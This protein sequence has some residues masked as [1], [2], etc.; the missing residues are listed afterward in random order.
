[1]CIENHR[2]I[3]GT[4]IGNIWSFLGH[5]YGKYVQLTDLKVPRNYSSSIW[6]HRIS[7]RLWERP[8]TP[9]VH[10]FGIF[11]PVTKPQNQL[12]LFLETT[13]KKKQENPW[14]ILKHIISS[15]L[16]KSETQQMVNFGTD[17]HR[18]IMKIRL[19]KS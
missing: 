11:E 7:I 14:N 6:Y 13:L 1:M 10:D 9:H 18:T 15:N 16:K 2:E 12:F 3:I 5:Y 19:N 17:V 4:I 8:K